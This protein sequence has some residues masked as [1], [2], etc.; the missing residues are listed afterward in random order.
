MYHAN[1][2]IQVTPLSCCSKKPWPH[3]RVELSTRTI[4]KHYRV[5]ISLC[6]SCVGREGELEID[7]LLF[8][9]AFVSHVICTLKPQAGSSPESQTSLPRLALVGFVC[10]RLCG[11]GAM[12]D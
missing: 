2:C 9:Y 7:N 8:N 4:Y 1:I 11:V 6:K 5:L 3:I 12:L 10:Q